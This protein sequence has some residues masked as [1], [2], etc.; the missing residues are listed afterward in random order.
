MQSVPGQRKLNFLIPKSYIEENETIQKIFD[1]GVFNLETHI[2]ADEERVDSVRK[3]KRTFRKQGVAVK[4]RLVC[5]E[6]S[7][8]YANLKIYDLDRNPGDSDDLMNEN[9]TDKNGMFALSGTTREFTDIEPVLF[10][11][12]DCEDG[13]RPCQ[14]RVRLIIPRRFIHDGTPTD[15]FD[16]GTL[17]MAMTFPQQDRSCYH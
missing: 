12:H 9:Y 15:W 16:I 17:N 13:I 2:E 4:G 8:K 6:A 10:I 1:I 11:Y 5:G 3:R 7:L 14:K